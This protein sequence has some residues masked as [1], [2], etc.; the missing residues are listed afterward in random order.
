MPT[1]PLPEPVRTFLAEPNPATM[2]TVRADGQPVSVATW[3]LLGGE[4]AD[5]IV[6]NLDAERVRLRHLR[7]EPRVSLTVLGRDD[8]STYVTVLGT[9]VDIADD[10]ALVGIDRQAQQYTGQLY[11]VRDRPR[12][13]VRIRIDRWFAWGAL[14]EV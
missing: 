9:A 1:L 14:K 12:V 10:P 2:T 6:V 7:T 5:E 11:P 3:Y 13:D 4:D 8:W